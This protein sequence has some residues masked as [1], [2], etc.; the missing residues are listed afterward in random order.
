MRNDNANWDTPE[1]DPIVVSSDAVTI[2]QITPKRQTLI[3]GINAHGASQ[4][5]L[6][7]WPGDITATQYALVLRRDRI[8][9]VNG[10]PRNDGWNDAIQCAVSN[11]TDGYAVFEIAGSGALA[12]LKHGGFIQVDEPSA[13]V[14]RSLFGTTVLLYRTGPSQFLLHINRMHAQAM[15]NQM[16]SRFANNLP[17]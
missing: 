2:R 14:A 16:K 1:T 13:S 17:D 10:E 11:V 3:S 5:A 7:S 6:V 9:E 4:L 8:L 12:L 15:R